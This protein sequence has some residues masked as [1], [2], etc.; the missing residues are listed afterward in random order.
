MSA[1]LLLP[2]AVGC[3]SVETAPE[4]A[5]PQGGLTFSDLPDGVSLTGGFSRPGPLVVSPDPTFGPVAAAARV[6]PESEYGCVLAAADPA[7][8]G[9]FRYRSVWLHFDA[10]PGMAPAT[11]RSVRRTPGA[12]RAA[13]CR[14]PQTREAVEALGALL[15]VDVEGDVEMGT[16]R[17][18]PATTTASFSFASSPPGDEPNEDGYVCMEGSDWTDDTKTLCRDADGVYSTPVFE[19]VE[20]GPGGGGG[21]GDTGG[22]EPGGDDPWPSPDDPPG[23]GEPSDCVSM[24]PGLP[25]LPGGGG[26]DPSDPTDPDPDTC[27]EPDH[28]AISGETGAAF[29][30]ALWES[31][32]VGT[33]NDRTPLQD[34][35]ENAYWA[36]RDSRGATSYV[37]LPDDWPRTACGIGMPADWRDYIPDEAYAF[38]HTHPYYLGED[39]KSLC[40]D[41]YE[42]NYQS[43]TN[44]DDIGFVFDAAAASGRHIKG[45]IIDGGA[46]TAYGSDTPLVEPIDRCGY[47]V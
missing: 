27:D 6:A 1:A 31:S 11:F 14:I 33:I 29:L 22:G 13:V 39:V 2:L 23:D 47:D 20:D 5:A 7:V 34:R 41:D 42:S 3:D 32:N 37:P 19:V 44:L 9:G 24:G 26:G 40:G 10:D 43:G 8:D 21:G 16:R 30:S 36:V 35:V 18:S 28:P 4:T 38:I 12:V 15:G 46:I 45:Y 17:A 25:C